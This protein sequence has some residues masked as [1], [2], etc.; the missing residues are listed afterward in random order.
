MARF[1]R[2]GDT[3]SAGVIVTL[4]FVDKGLALPVVVTM[5]ASG[6]VALVTGAL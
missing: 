3:F 5:V 1:V 2:K 4:P 6:A